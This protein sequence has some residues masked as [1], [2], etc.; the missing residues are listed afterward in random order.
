[1]G[2]NR[3]TDFHRVLRFSVFFF[4]SVFLLSLWPCPG[5]SAEGNAWGKL[6]MESWG[7]SSYIEPI[8]QLGS[9]PDNEL[10]MFPEVEIGLRTTVGPGQYPKRPVGVTQP[11]P[12]RSLNT[13]G[14][15][16]SD[17]RAELPMLN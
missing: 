4:V 7:E 15:V 2:R 14:K 17:S 9:L 10:A 8:D 3:E 13:Y 12:A 1:M 11:L 16:E 6:E 5:A